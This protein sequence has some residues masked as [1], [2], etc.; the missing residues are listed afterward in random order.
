MPTKCWDCG[1]QAIPFPEGR[2]CPLCV[3]A[4]S[5]PGFLRRGRDAQPF[6]PVLIF[7]D[8]QGNI[9]F[10]GRNDAPAP[11]GFKPVKLTDIRQVRKFERQMNDRER[12]RHEIAI[13]GERTAFSEVQRRN[14]EELRAAMRHMTPAGR[15]LARAAM[16][17]GDR[18]DSQ[19]R[20]SF[21]AGFHIEVFSQDSG[22][23]EAYRDERTD[24]KSR[25][26]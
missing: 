15:E 11:E 26:K 6:D 19:P 4:D 20:G 21:D 7:E 2:P 5:A 22:N 13:E 17:E 1:Q 12:V 18:Q 23:R 10:P 24:W 25:R 14:R 9:R 3:A 16:E 8:A